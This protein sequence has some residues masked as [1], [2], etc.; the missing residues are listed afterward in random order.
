M[1]AFKTVLR[2]ELEDHFNSWRFITLFLLIFLP[3]IYYIWRVLGNI[4]QTVTSATSTTFLEMFTRPFT[5]STLPIL[6]TTFYELVVMLIPIVGIA[7]GLDAINSERN[8][9]TL[10]HLIAQPIY[11]DNVIN[12]K[13]MAGVLTIAVIMTSVVLISCGLGVRIL[14]IIPSAEEA[15]R[16][17][18]FLIMSIVYGCFWLGLSILFSILFKRV[19]ASALVSVAVWLFFAI[20]FQLIIMALGNNIDVSTPESAMSGLNTIITVSRI[21]PMQ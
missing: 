5:E 1:V 15:W 17:F 19:S 3:S 7:L 16:I 2:K 13:F 4:Q 9:G 11:R 18:F 8:N 14:G 21:S 20:I 12:A 10:S 6:P